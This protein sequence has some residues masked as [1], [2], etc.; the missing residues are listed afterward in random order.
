MYFDAPIAKNKTKKPFIFI[1]T[2]TKIAKIVPPWGTSAGG[3]GQAQTF[4]QTLV[5]TR[6]PL[7]SPVPP[8]LRSLSVSL[9]PEAAQDTLSRQENPCRLQILLPWASNTL[10]LQSKQAWVSG[11]VP[12]LFPVH[13]RHDRGY[14]RT[15]IGAGVEGISWSGSSQCHLALTGQLWACTATVLGGCEG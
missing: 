5:V 7:P 13:G 4:C 2:A 3:G 14:F 11:P 6:A 8:S 15:G 1:R 9:P 10:M 12:E